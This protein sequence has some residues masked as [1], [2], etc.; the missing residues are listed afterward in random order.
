MPPPKLTWNLQY[1][2]AL[3]L[4][5]YTYVWRPKRWFRGVVYG[6]CLFELDECCHGFQK[7]EK[8]INY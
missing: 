1:N 2:G 5:T 3:P 4:A 7:R 8:L 6:D